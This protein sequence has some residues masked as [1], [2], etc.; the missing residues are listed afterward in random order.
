MLKKDWKS[1][2]RQTKNNKR[3]RNKDM[4][5]KYTKRGGRFIMV[6]IANKSSRE[7]R[8]PKLKTP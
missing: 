1:T 7:A 6:H 2:K 8:S 3:R 5:G 4:Y